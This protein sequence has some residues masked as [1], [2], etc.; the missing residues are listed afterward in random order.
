M[1]YFL[2][3][4]GVVV[5]VA[6]LVTYSSRPRPSNDSINGMR[7]RKANESDAAWESGLRV[8]L[9][10]SVSVGIIGVVG[11]FLSILLAE[12]WF[13]PVVAATFILMIGLLILGAVLLDRRVKREAS[14]EAGLG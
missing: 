7:R 8:Y 6:N 11:G 13:I 5:L 14:R 9:P 10:F 4:I 2:I 3:V 12:Q 1:G